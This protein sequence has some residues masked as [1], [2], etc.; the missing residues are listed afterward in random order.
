MKK[1]NKHEIKINELRTNN[2]MGSIDIKFENIKSN[3][4]QATVLFVYRNGRESCIQI[5]FNDR[6]VEITT[7]QDIILRMSR[8]K[9]LVRKYY[10]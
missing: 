1:T 2:E 8:Y 4:G 6:E 9:K 3:F 7:Y 10:D 5:V